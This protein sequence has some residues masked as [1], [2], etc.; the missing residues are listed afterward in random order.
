MVSKIK[1]LRLI[2]FKGVSDKEYEINGQNIEIKGQNG[3]GKTTIATAFYWVFAD[4]DYDLHSNPSIRKIG[5]EESDPRVEIILD[6]DGKEIS[7]AKIQKRTVRKSRTGGADS[8]SLKNIYE[9]NSVEYGERDF[10]VKLMEYGFD[11]DLFLPLS[12]PE[13]FTSKKADEMR[14]VL[15]SMVGNYSDL[16]IASMTKGCDLVSEMLKTYSMEEIKAKQNST[17]KKIR[18][19]YGKSGELLV[20]KIKGLESAKVDI[21]VAEL[22]LAKKAVMDE[23]NINLDKQTDMSKQ[24]SGFQELSNAIFEL[25]FAQGDLKAKAHETTMTMSKQFDVKVSQARAKCDDIVDKIMETDLMIKRTEKNLV[26]AKDDIETCRM[27]WKRVHE[28]KFDES[29]LI[30]PTCGQDLPEDKKVA[31]VKDF[32]EKKQKQLDNITVKGNSLKC[33]IERIERE[34][35]TLAEMKDSLKQDKFEAEKELAEAKAAYVD[36]LRTKDASESD[37]W[38]DL[39]KQIDEKEKVL[40]DFS[41][42]QDIQVNLK[43]EESELRLKLNEIMAE[44]AKSQNNVHIDERISKLRADQIKYEQDIADAENILDQLNLLG[45]KKNEILSDEINKNF[46]LVKYK[47]FDY[48]KNGEYKEVCVP[49]FKGKDMNVSTNTGLEI[50]MKLDI[51]NGLQRFYG[52]SYPVFVDGAECLD[53]NSKKSIQMDCQMV[54]LTVSDDEELKIVEV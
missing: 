47:L 48:Q 5:E 10:K 43:H 28:T 51:I 25:K 53:T 13:V 6:I 18:E 19:V 40:K 34:L 23:L 42:I 15:F 33:S 46:K 11:I 24:L 50:M 54:Y 52:I 39:Q 2:N 41:S 1:S 14:K 7:V 30:C 8:V 21:D 35:S 36:S 44:I 38:K 26:N 20:A 9:V 22:E 12:H 49:T 31:L 45:K 27:D 29:A 3:A 4:R 32:G 16:E 17:I 37:E